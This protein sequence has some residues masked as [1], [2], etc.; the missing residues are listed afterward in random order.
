M[1]FP[2]DDATGTFD[3]TTT[4]TNALT[5]EIDNFAVTADPIK[6]T[7]EHEA[8]VKEIREALLSGKFEILKYEYKIEKYSQMKRVVTIRYF[9]DKT[10]GRRSYG[11]Q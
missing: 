8:L 6:E 7:E 4:G 1:S 9:P 10:K 5:F 11:I 2:Q 3:L